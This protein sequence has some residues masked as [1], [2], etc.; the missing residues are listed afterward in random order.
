M[1]V[2]KSNGQDDRAGMTSD[3]LIG[4]SNEGCMDVLSSQLDHLV[5]LLFSA[6]IPTSFHDL[7]K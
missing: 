5:R 6:S 4:T 2:L 3:I 1:Q 7:F